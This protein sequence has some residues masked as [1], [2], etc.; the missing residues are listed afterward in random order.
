MNELDFCLHGSYWLADHNILTLKILKT[1][2]IFKN[3]YLV[4][5]LLRLL[6]I[7]YR[8]EIITD[9]FKNDD[10]EKV[11]KYF[12]VLYS[13]HFKVKCHQNFSYARAAAEH[14]L[15]C[16]LWHRGQIVAELLLKLLDAWWFL[17]WIITISKFRVFLIKLYQHE[18]F[19]TSPFFLSA[20]WL[21]PFWIL[22][23]TVFFLHNKSETG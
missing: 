7:N 2:K 16:S 3:I 14:A 13:L 17:T 18:F 15:K 5:D 8:F 21:S 12:S 10:F 4:F 11:K 19:L 23:H 9:S 1:K 22:L 20:I 6:D